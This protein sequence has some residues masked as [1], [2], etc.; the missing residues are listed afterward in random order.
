MNSH[1]LQK[2]KMSSLVETD[3][4]FRRNTSLWSMLSGSAR[5]LPPR[6]AGGARL[7]LA[8]LGERVNSTGSLSDTIKSLGLGLGGRSAEIA[9]MNI[10]PRKFPNQAERWDRTFARALG[11]DDVPVRRDIAAAAISARPAYDSYSNQLLFA[12]RDTPA[13]I[14]KQLGRAALTRDT[15]ASKLTRYGLTAPRNKFLSSALGAA[16]AIPGAALGGLAAGPAGA[17]AG[18]LAAPPAMRRAVEARLQVGDSIAA[19]RLVNSR[20]A[21]VASEEFLK[22]YNKA[23]RASRRGFLSRRLM[24]AALLG[25]LPIAAAAMLPP[26]YLKAFN[27]ATGLGYYHTLL[28]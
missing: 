15:D 20:L 6:G 12:T 3:P 2:L 16:S 25:S 5:D 7:A 10:D 9:T 18:A 26:E 1:T 24:P 23:A 19:D 13:N 11:V 8:S 21:P 28:K 4:S 14:T 27:D 17:V 22:N